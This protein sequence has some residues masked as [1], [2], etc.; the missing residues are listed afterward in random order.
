MIWLLIVLGI[1]GLLFLF[2][3]TCILNN[4]KPGDKDHNT[5]SFLVCTGILLIVGFS[6]GMYENGKEWGWK[7]AE[8][9]M[10]TGGTGKYVLTTQ[11][12]KTVTWDKKP[13]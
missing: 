2:S 4:N 8:I 12:D 9:H 7:E 13:L 11:P 6:I 1:L 5:G 3:G 10:K